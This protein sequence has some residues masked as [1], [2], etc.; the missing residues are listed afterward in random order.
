MVL[1]D[2]ISPL[3]VQ[4]PASLMLPS[5]AAKG[6]QFG[7]SLMAREHCSPPVPQGKVTTK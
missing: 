4:P 2:E 6:V 7:I 3:P 5:L 1:S